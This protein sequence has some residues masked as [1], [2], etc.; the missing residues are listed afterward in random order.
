MKKHENCSIEELV[1]KFTQ[2]ALAR[3]FAMKNNDAKSAN[4]AFEEEASLLRELETHGPS[5]VMRLVSLLDSHDPWVRCD[6]A[7]PLLFFL[8]EQGKIA[9]QQ[10]VGQERGALRTMATRKVEAVVGKMLSG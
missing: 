6:S 3:G 2:A 10:I 8:P 7:I 5:G 1:T 9:L 4:T